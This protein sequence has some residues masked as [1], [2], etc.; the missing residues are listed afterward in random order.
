MGV[1]LKPDPAGADATLA[2]HDSGPPKEKKKDEI[3]G[4]TV[5]ILNVDSRNIEEPV[6]ERSL[7]AAY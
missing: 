1:E 4:A 6:D 5:I 3:L 7:P 2:G